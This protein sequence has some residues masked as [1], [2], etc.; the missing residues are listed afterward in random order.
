[1]EEQGHENDG[2]EEW[3]HETVQMEEWEQNHA[4]VE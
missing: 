2:L 4:G 3:G 1:M